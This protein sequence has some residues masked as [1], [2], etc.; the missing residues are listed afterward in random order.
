MQQR[1]LTSLQNCTI[2]IQFWLSGLYIWYL[3]SIRKLQVGLQEGCGVTSS[4]YLTACG[5]SGY[6]ATNY[7]YPHQ[8][9]QR[10]NYN[11]SRFYDPMLWLLILETWN[12]IFFVNDWKS[13]PG[14]GSQPYPSIST[15][16]LPAAAAGADVWKFATRVQTRFQTQSVHRHPVRQRAQCASTAPQQLQ[17]N[18]TEKTRFRRIAGEWECD[19]RMRNENWG[20]CLIVIVFYL[21]KCQS[22]VSLHYSE[23]IASCQLSASLQ[24]DDCQLSCLRHISPLHLYISPSLQRLQRWQG[25]STSPCLQCCSVSG[26]ITW[27]RHQH[28]HQPHWSLTLAVRPRP[29]ASG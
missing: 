10:N 7:K 20:S 1:I 17:H 22:S 8:H 14:A 6:K 24:H 4:L 25:V 2:D 5:L 26:C 19:L 29:V 12:N 18:N 3:V 23:C 28:Q 11:K 27:S 21:G 16:L 13:P 9:H 15:Y